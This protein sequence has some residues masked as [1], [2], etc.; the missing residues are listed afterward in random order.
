MFIQLSIQELKGETGKQTSL[1]GSAKSDIFRLYKSENPVCET[2]L[3]N[4]I[5][6]HTYSYSNM[7]QSHIHIQAQSHVSLLFGKAA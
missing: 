2:I 1:W 7:L 4:M 5:N 6:S 3:I